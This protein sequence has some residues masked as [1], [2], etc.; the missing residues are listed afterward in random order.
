MVSA[1]AVDEKKGVE[2]A[3]AIFRETIERNVRARC[4]GSCRYCQA[5][6]GGPTGRYEEWDDLASW[7]FGYC[8]NKCRLAAG[9]PR[10]FDIDKALSVL[11]PQPT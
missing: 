2:D 1:P 10:E 4:Q 8:S 5:V 9:E 6:Y 11:F 3:Q 7:I